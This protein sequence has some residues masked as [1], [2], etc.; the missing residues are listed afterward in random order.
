MKL[1]RLPRCMFRFC[2]WG[3]WNFSKWSVINANVCVREWQKW[4]KQEL[5]CFLFWLISGEELWRERGSVKRRDACRCSYTLCT[6]IPLSILSIACAFRRIGN[7]QPLALVH[8]LFSK[9]S[10]PSTPFS[11]RN[12]QKIH[13][14]FSFSRFLF[15]MELKSLSLTIQI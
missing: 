8:T 5:K 14:P 11:P 10:P 12:F 3:E 4:Y 7:H 2:V 1:T 6:T 13:P 15:V 9:Q